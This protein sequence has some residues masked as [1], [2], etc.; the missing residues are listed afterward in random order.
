MSDDDDLPIK[1]IETVIVPTQS[2]VYTKVSQYLY[3]NFC[4]YSQL[5]IKFGKIQNYKLGKAL[6]C[7]RFSNVFKGTDGKRI[8]ALKIYKEVKPNY[9]KREIFI[10]KALKKCKN[11]VRL[12]DVVQDS[13]SGAIALVLTF[14][15]NVDWKDYFST[16]SLHDAKI[17]M[18]KLLTALQEM[19][20]HGI[21]HRDIK[22]HNI[23]YNP[24]TK[25]L[26]LGDFGLA[27]VYFPN[28]QYEVGV[29][30]VRFMPPEMLL[31]Y[32]YY[33][34]AVDIWSAGVVLAEIMI[35]SP[36]FKG[37]FPLDILYSIS[38]LYTASPLLVFADKMNIDVKGPFLEC[39]SS[40]SFPALDD[41]LQRAKPEF[42]DENLL[43]LLKQMLMIDPALRITALDALN[44]PAFNDIRKELGCQ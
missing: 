38:K 6:G 37:E 7:G 44:H 33:S 14:H 31:Q 15:K 10:Q 16:F 18:Y 13:L 3:P 4:Q 23:L 21:M 25:S 32:K 11:L 40:T 41:M 12:H 27:E 2:K 17:Y 9:I 28:H 29:G 20:S 22:Q 36:F 43:N 5:N 35:E 1:N 34:Y 39:L 19:H 8:Y 26:H 42:K 24:K 30:T